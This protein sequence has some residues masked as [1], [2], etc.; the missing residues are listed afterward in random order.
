VDPNPYQS[1]KLG[2]DSHQSEK[3][4]PDPQHCF[5]EDGENSGLVT[6]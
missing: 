5:L 3:K 6:P 2:P 1:E 4:D